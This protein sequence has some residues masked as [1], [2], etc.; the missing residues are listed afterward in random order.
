MKTTKAFLQAQLDQANQA[1]AK[2][3]AERDA[4]RKEVRRME[5]RALESS[6]A[7]AQLRLQ[8]IAMQEPPNA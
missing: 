4:A 3:L 5:V 7:A 1:T 8:L 6:I 2:A